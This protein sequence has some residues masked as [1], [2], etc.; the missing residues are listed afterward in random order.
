MYRSFSKEL[1]RAIS[2]LRLAVR[3]ESM[4]WANVWRYSQRNGLLPGLHFPL[5]GF[6][7]LSFGLSSPMKLAFALNDH[8]SG[9]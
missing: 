4:N 6:D 2:R 7:P 5:P 9:V 1:D 8:G 3:G